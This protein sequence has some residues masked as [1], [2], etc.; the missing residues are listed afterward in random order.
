M[1]FESLLDEEVGLRRNVQTR[2]DKRYL[3]HR[4][5]L[6]SV[7]KSAATNGRVALNYYHTCTI[8]AV[9]LLLHRSNCQLPADDTASQIHFKTKKYI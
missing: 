7:M 4:Y 8:S 6:L 9:G 5:I 3:L 1:N 2:N